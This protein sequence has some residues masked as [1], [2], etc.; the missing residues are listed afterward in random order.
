MG[1]IHGSHRF[2]LLSGQSWEESH[3]MLPSAIEEVSSI[4]VVQVK[5]VT[6]NPLTSEL[7]NDILVTYYISPEIHTLETTAVSHEEHPRGGT[8]NEYGQDHFQLMKSQNQKDSN[9]I[10]TLNPFS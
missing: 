9:T 10:P 5:A 7:P 2:G 8:H 4:S 3:H 1:C 6:T